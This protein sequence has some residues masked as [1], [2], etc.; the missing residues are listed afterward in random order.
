M[1]SI[2]PEVPRIFEFKDYRA[3]L[4]AHFEYRKSREPEFSL[5]VFSRNPHLKLASSSFISAVLKGRKNLSQG[6]RLRFGK[7]L[8][9]K[10]AEQEYFE[11]MVQANQGKTADERAHYQSRLGRFHGSRARSLADS[12]YRFYDRWWYP[13]VWHWIGLNPIQANPARIARAIRPRIEPAQAEE[14]IQVLLDLKLIKR[15]ANGYAVTE[16]HLA[17]RPRLTEEVGRMHARSNLRLALDEL[18]RPHPGPGEYHVWSF[19]LSARGRERLREKL[20]ALR[21]EVRELVA[22]SANSDAAIDQGASA[23]GTGVY[24]LA[25]Q[26]FPCSDDEAVESV[27]ARLASPK[28]AAPR[29]AAPRSAAPRFA[30][31]SGTSAEIAVL[32]A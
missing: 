27:T 22:E 6:L 18:E 13:V 19:S 2:R 16:R 26:L 17:W 24:A 4:L 30:A 23:G 12:E 14:A 5:R 29:S 28:L 20:E 8:G 3:F 31:L 25:L 10:P 7:A 1:G 11:M 21:S 32:P 9:L 15:L